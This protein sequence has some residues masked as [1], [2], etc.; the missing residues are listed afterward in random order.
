MHCV[1]ALSRTPAVAALQGMLTHGLTADQSL[2]RIAKALPGAR[3]NKTFREVLARQWGGDELRN[4]AQSAPLGDPPESR[5][6]S[7][8][9]A[10][11]A[12]VVRH[13]G[14][15][16]EQLMP[17]VALQRTLTLVSART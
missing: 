17:S 2:A 5:R 15:P 4:R 9:L 13:E 3:P 16:R 6:D 10:R 14:R 12:S 7:A 8:N 1:P 11:L